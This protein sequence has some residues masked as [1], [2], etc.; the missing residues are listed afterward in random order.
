MYNFDK[1]SMKLYYNSTDRYD[2]EG[3]TLVFP[4]VIFLMRFVNDTGYFPR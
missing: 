4:A 2:K 1:W 3:N